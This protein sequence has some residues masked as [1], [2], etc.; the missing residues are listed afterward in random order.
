MHKQIFSLLLPAIV[1]C[2]AVDVAVA[3]TC[4]QTPSPCASF[5]D[6]PVV[7]VG[8][9][10]SIEETKV[11]IV[12]FGE[13]RTV[14]TSLLA[15]FTVEEPL[16]GIKLK[17]ALVDTGGG[18]GDCG[19]PFEEGHRYPVY[20]FRGE[21]EALNS[22]ISRTVIGDG[23]T[24]K[25]ARLSANIC[26]RT[27]ELE[28]ATD[29]VELLRGLVK[30][31]RESRIFGSVD[32]H[33]RRLGKYEYDIDRVGPMSNIKLIAQ[34]ANDR[35]ETT[36]DQNGRYRISNLKPGK[37]KLSV[38]LPEGYSS[39]FDFVR[40]IVDLDIGPDTCVEHSFDAQIDG[41][42]GGHVFAA[43]G[44]PVPDQVQVSI[45]T[46]ES[47]T[48]GMTGVE[49]RSEYT[50]NLGWYEFDGLLPGKYL[51][52]ISIADAPQKHTPYATTYYP[53]T[54]D[55]AQARVFTLELGQKLTN[56]DFRL[57]PKLPEIILSG[58]VVDG[59][60]NPVDEVDVDIFDQENPDET[61]FGEDVKTDKQGRFTIRGFSG[62][63]YFL[64]ALKAQDYFE[65]TGSQSALVPV[66]TNVPTGTV[67]LV[68][69][70][71]G[72]FLK[73]QK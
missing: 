26:S 28:D 67:K 10:T 66:D 9:V 62:R 25:A 54:P 44:Q 58:I 63:R 34:S 33:A 51:L 59:A 48:K 24:G 50:K 20:A 42:I 55:R 31:K 6:T 61:L 35:Y 68:L 43:D 36:T 45:V 65:G 41:R 56:I 19:Y 29:D 64:H 13:K 15:H 60:G 2:C 39:L 69:N 4:M 1:L 72:I 40:T 12:R 38:L 5:K 49:S 7:F 37:Y 71:S 70:Q 14:R 57:P 30:G 73:K 47:S 22:S 53:N 46:L 52:G 8:L 17:T 27:R 11:D 21:D 16:K 3:C 18:G 32:E 23:R